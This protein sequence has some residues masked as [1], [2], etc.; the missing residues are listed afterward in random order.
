MADQF[1][2]LTPGGRIVWGS[3]TERATHDY[4]NKPYEPGK[5]PFQFGLAI[6]KDAQGMN[7]LLGSL[8]NVAVSGYPNKAG[9]HQRIHN[10]YSSGFTRGDF[11]FK[12][13][14]GDKPNAEGVVNPNT[15]GCWVLAFSTNLPI[16]ATHYN[17]IP[18]VPNNAE[19]D[20]KEIYRGAY[21]DVHLS[22]SANGNEDRTAGIYLNPNAVR[23]LGHGERIVG[24]ISTEQAFGSAPAPVLPVGASAMPVGPTAAAP[25]VPGL[26]QQ[27]QA[28][29]VPQV[30]GLPQ[31]PQYQPQ[32]PQVPQVP[33]PQYQPQAPQVPQVPGLPQ[34]QYQ[35]QAPQVP[36]VPTLP[37]HGQ[38]P[39][40]TTSPSN[41]APAYPQILQPPAVS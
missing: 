35:P 36:Q 38:P 22:S 20:P 26:P 28:P 32:A 33:Q 2:T 6:R 37:G 25:Q 13:K 9:I 1:Q 12:I 31:Q 4:D 27:P 15:A 21:A 11:S 14:D 24:G 18:G 5:G 30:P 29:Q 7:E 3:I 23:L 41:P 17:I 34:Q 19:I 39:S 8:Y 10:E 16:K 40:M